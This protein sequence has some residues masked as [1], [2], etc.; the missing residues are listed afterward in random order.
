MASRFMP[1]RVSFLLAILLM[2]HTAPAAAQTT[3]APQRTGEPL[4]YT[5]SFPEP[6]THYMDIS[7][8]VPTSARTEI[9]LMMAVWTPGS[10]LVREFSR[11]VEGV[12]AATPDGRALEVEKSDKN[13]WRVATR[14]AASVTVKYKVYGREMSVRTNWIESGFA[15]VNGAPT[16]LTL[17]DRTPRPH[18]VVLL[19][20]AGWR[21]SMTSLPAQPGGGEHRYVAPDYDTLVDSPILL[22]NPAVYEFTV[23]GKPH[24]LVNEGEAGVFDGARAAKDLQRVV[25]A[26]RAF[27]GF[28]PYDKYLFLNVISEAGGGLEHKSSATLM[29]SRWT[30]RTRGAYLAWLETASHELFHAWNV[31]RL[32]PVELGPFDYESE[33]H[34]RSLWMVEGVTDY[35]GDVM[36]RRAGLSAREEYLDSLSAKIEELQTTPGRAV[37]PAESASFD[38]WIKYYRPDENSAN[39]SVSYYTKG[40]VIGFLLDGRIRKATN[41]RRSLDDAMRLAYQ[42]FSGAKGYTPDELRGVMEEVAGVSLRTFWDASVEGTA[43]LDYTEALDALGLRFRPAPLMGNRAWLGASTRNDGGRLVVS[44]V[45]RD[46]PAWN[47]GLN[48]DDEILAIGDFR[49]RADRLDSRLDLYRPGE[50][51]TILVARREQLQRLE[52]TFGAEPSRAWRLEPNPAATAEQQKTLADWLK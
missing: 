33:V 39:T 37:Q 3:P 38:A 12:T 7:V 11:H 46:S 2:P 51:V 17:A 27:W 9:E 25:E 43:E 6:H 45:R 47:A 50:R 40:A 41:G 20:A 19:P 48:V 16:F 14:G 49:I 24:Y 18:E 35:Y 13:R 32:R 52:V 23:D 29:T 21:R 10:Y 42:R 1:R 8:V 28:L 44:Q 26:Q 34:T 30:T 4:R 22:G 5:V 36:V 31:K 15:L